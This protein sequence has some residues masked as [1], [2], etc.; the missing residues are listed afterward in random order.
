[1]S[2][3]KE[4]EILE[5]INNGADAAVFDLIVTRF[6]QIPYYFDKKEILRD[7]IELSPAGMTMLFRKVLKSFKKDEIPL[8]FGL[9]NASSFFDLLVNLRNELEKKVIL[10]LMTFLIMKKIAN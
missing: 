4:K 8:Y 6:K 7:Q 2:F 5:R 10:S 9:Q 3:E 1:M